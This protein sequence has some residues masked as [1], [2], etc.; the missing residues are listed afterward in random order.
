[1]FLLGPTSI[2]KGFIVK[3]IF[4]VFKFLE[5]F[6]IRIKLISFGQMIR[7]LMEKDPEFKK[8]Y[9]ET[10]SRGRLVDDPMAIKLFEEKLQEFSRESPHLIIVDGF[11]RTTVQI[12][13]AIENGYLQ[14]K[15]HVFMVEGSFETCLERFT[16]RS[17]RD[18]S[19]TEVEIETF[20]YRYHLHTDSAPD[21]RAL[22]K[23]TDA[24]IHDIDGNRD[25]AEFVA[26][27]IIAILMPIV[28][29]TACAVK[30]APVDEILD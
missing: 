14:D 24:Q 27:D 9:A 29:V 13:H 20:R 16:E 25:I 30:T 5:L 26:P 17:K 19:R 4:R 10:L 8:Q 28:C 23:E 2:G 12:R 7:D 18:K 22:F 1:M 3:L 15:D 21:L 6:G 11:C